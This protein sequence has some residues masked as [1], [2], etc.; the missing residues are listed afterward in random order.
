MSVLG[1]V[2]ERLKYLAELPELTS[3]FFDEP[4]VDLSL[5]TDNKQL[6]KI[7]HSELVRLLKTV[8]KKLENTTFTADEIQTALNQLLEETGQKPGVLFSLTRIATTWAPFSPNLA[9]SLAVLGKETS[10]NRI[11][12]AIQ[13]LS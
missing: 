7:E 11:E 13:N 6:K 8:A 4:V 9:E 2:Q 1:L 12:K 5:I 3:F 10:L